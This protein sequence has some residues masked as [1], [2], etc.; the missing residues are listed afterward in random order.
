MSTIFV[1][2]FDLSFLIYLEV[3]LLTRKMRPTTII[4]LAVG[5]FT[6]TLCPPPFIAQSKTLQVE[7][8][9]RIKTI[10]VGVSQPILK[11]RSAFYFCEIYIT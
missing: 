7:C 10:K 8:S 6:S 3:A 4:R 1:E 2:A 11:M 5:T 9:E